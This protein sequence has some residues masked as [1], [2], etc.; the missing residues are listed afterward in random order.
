MVWYNGFIS[1]TY[2]MFDFRE[3]YMRKT[4]FSLMFL[5]ANVL[6]LSGCEATSNKA[7][8]LSVVYCI[9]AIFSL[10]I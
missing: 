2:F 7:I 3:R 5:V 8:S 4:L 10:T 6:C 9:V 1:S